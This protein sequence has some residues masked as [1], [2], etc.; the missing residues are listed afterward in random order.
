[1]QKPVSREALVQEAAFWAKMQALAK[2]DP[3]RQCHK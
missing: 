3:G 2:N 1:M